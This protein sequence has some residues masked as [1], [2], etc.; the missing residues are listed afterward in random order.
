MRPD[1]PAGSA[2]SSDTFPE[3]SAQRRIWRDKLIAC[4]CPISA[5]LSGLGFATVE[6]ILPSPRHF[7]PT[8]AYLLLFVVSVVPG[9]RPLMRAW[10]LGI[11]LP[12]IC[13][14]SIAE[15]G[16]APNIFA[17]L[18]LGIGFVRLIFSFRRAM[19]ISGI[20][21][22]GLFTMGGL[23]I[24]GRV[25]VGPSWVMSLDPAVPANVIRIFFVFGIQVVGVLA[26][27]G[28]VLR[29]IETLLTEKAAAMDSLR[30][31]SAA[32]ERLRD[33]LAAREKADVKARDLEQLGRLASYFGHDTNNALQV[34]WSSIAMLR[35]P[36]S[37]GA[38]RNGALTTLEDAAS[39][40]R[41]LS[42]Q[43]RAF[44]PGRGQVAGRS[45]LAAVL[46]AT[47]RM[48]T[49]VF[50]REIEIVVADTPAATVGMAEGELQRVLINL[51]MNGR[52][53]MEG[54]GKLT[55]RSQLGDA[56]GKPTSG[57]PT[58]VAIEISDTGAGMPTDVQQNVFEPFFTTKGERGTGLGLSSVRDR[59][60]ATGGTVRLESQPGRGT[61]VTVILPILPNLPNLPMLTAPAPAQSAR[62]ST[63]TR[64]LVVE[65]PVVRSAL[66]RALRGQGFAATAA[67]T[68][69]DG[70]A[71][72]RAAESPFSMLV[73][74]STSS[75]E[76]RSLVHAFR[77]RSPGGQVILCEND[78][79][80]DADPGETA[81]VTTLLKPFTLPELLR[82][83]EA[84]LPAD[85][86]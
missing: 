12:G 43:L 75:D 23:L 84:R 7:A 49:Q 77:G 40:I 51:A 64:V 18:L 47:V 85:Q 65:E 38:Q 39:Q 13:V 8:L 66:L 82:H 60:E 22:G 27:L 11:G 16:L 86:E 48:L 41:T 59:V 73:V 54:A 30:I 20:L 29:K 17:G 74:G 45:D 6:F 78:E 83:I 2:Q 36:A 69:S 33:E 10:L 21:L 44:G 28:Y 79:A 42:M 52:D 4:I 9:I 61:A 15:F 26:V 1:L 70:L 25:R 53:A 56:H 3:L 63:A 68:A 5:V 55:I 80:A 67:D 62:R 81:G 50:P 58:H 35:S 24:S 76:A 32:K 37:T 46:H 14:V 34:V 31:E 71:A 72:L 19:I 57:A